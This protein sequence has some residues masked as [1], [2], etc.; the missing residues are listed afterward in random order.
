[1]AITRSPEIGEIQSEI[2]GTKSDLAQVRAAYYPQLES[3]ALV[4]P[5]E[6]AKEPLIVNGRITDPSPS[7]SASSIGI[8]GGWT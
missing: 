7:L 4:G 3:T 2:A 1:M 8:L 5:V 6:D